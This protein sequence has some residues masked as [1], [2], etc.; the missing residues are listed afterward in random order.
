MSAAYNTTDAPDS[1]ALRKKYRGNILFVQI[2]FGVFAI[3]VFFRAYQLQILGNA[4]LNHLTDTQYKAKFVVNP[5]RG[6]IF[7][8]NG[9]PL[10][11]DIEVSSVAIH[12]HQITDPAGVKSLLL[13]QTGASSSLIDKKLASTKKFEFIERRLPQENG[14]IIDQADLKGI[15]VL[16]EYLRYYPNQEMAGQL[17]GAVGLDAK[18]LGGLELSYDKTLR[19]HSTKKNAEK[20]ARGRL[21]SPLINDEEIYHDLTLTIDTTI[22]HI[23][24]AALNEAGVK[25]NAKSGFAIVM[26]PA[27]G[28]VLAMANYPPFNPNHFGDYPM[29][30]WKNH[31]LLDVYEPGSTFKTMLMGAALGTGK[32]KATDTFNCE[33]GNFAIGRDTIHDHGSG[34]GMLDAK[35]ILQVSSNIGVTK[36][37]MKIGPKPFYDFL[38]H[39]GFGQSTK[40]GFIGEGAGSLHHYKAWKPIEFSNISFGQGVSVTGIQLISAYAAIANG[41]MHRQ[42]LLVKRIESS[43]GN[44]ITENRAKELGR[45]LAENQAAILSDMLHSVTQTGGTAPAAHVEGYLSAGKTGTA[46]K[47]DPLTRSYAAHDYVSSFIGFAPAKAPTL[48]IYVVFDTPR[49]NGYFG[50][51]TAAPVFKTIAAKT[52]AYRG[53]VPTEPLQPGKIGQQDAGTKESLAKKLSPTQLREQHAQM[54]L[55][56]IESQQV[57]DL[58]GLSL[59]KVLQ[60]T[61][62]Q[63]IELQLKGSGIVVRQDPPAGSRLSHVKMLTLELAEGT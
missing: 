62:T 31:A 35:T 49:K 24:E 10:A 17:L 42:P 55:A 33:G 6:S 43:D 16:S 25:H 23:T 30:H 12:P 45:I 36:I 47:F 50:G 60:I 26:D 58:R 27:T 39:M 8:R 41:G 44:T 22:Q 9:Q 2:F 11:V 29:E 54:A 7:D 21:F 48:A 19:T 52:L 34:Y 15:Q 63:N 14:N 4:R 38:T 3:L 56:A 40:I 18:A 57:P 46:Q 32:V 28:E 1:D 61:N 5:K 13:K 59:R 20:D 53:I 51:A 37:A